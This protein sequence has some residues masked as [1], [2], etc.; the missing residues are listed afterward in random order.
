[1]SE[2]LKLRAEDAD[3]LKV[4]S[5]ALQDAVM[6]VGD[7]TY[8]AKRRTFALVANRFRWEQSGDAPKPVRGRALHS[9]VQ[10]GLHFDDVFAVG[11]QGFD[12]QA[13]DKLLSLL[14]IECQAGE[15]GGAT[16]TLQFS[17]GA[18]VRLDVECVNA[19]LTDIGESWTTENL[20][21]HPVD[22]TD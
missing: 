20:P 16:V 4:M 10:C 18:G 19:H 15:D 11:S 5:A 3:D 2:G 13:A 12:P 17:G 14:A 8:L 22:E 9:R 6:R 1:M 7:M 21:S